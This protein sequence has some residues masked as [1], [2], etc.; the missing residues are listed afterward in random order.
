MTPIPALHPGRSG[1][2]GHH[3]SRPYLAGTPLRPV[4][5]GHRPHEPAFSPSG[6]PAPPRWNRPARPGSSPRSTHPPAIPI[7]QR[8]PRLT[9]R[10]ARAHRAPPANRWRPRP[11]H[12]GGSECGQ[13]SRRL[14]TSRTDQRSQDSRNSGVVCREPNHLSPA[15]QTFVV[16]ALADVGATR[17]GTT[18]HG[19]LSFVRPVSVGRFL[20]GLAQWRPLPELPCREPFAPKPVLGVDDPVRL[21]HHEGVA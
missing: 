11:A 1:Q 4:Q 3:V 16:T 6:C 20:T 5:P 14:I 21:D 8:R 15:P 13:N 9:D 10:H 19:R 12:G 7:H 2:P 17:T 18:W